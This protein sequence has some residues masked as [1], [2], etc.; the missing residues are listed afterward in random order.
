MNEK[1]NNE[2]SNLRSN[3]RNVIR[4]LNIGKIPTFINAYLVR[5]YSWK[6]HG[7]YYSMYKDDSMLFCATGLPYTPN[8]KRHSFMETLDKLIENQEMRP[9][10]LFLGGKFIKWS[11]ILIIKN[12]A[13]TYLLASHFMEDGCDYNIMQLPE[14]SVTYTE[15]NKN[16]SDEIFIFDQDGKYV[17][18]PK[19]YVPYTT[20]SI[21][22]DDVY[23]EKG[24]SKYNTKTQLKLEPEYKVQSNNI[25]LFDTEGY[26]IHNPDLFMNGLNLF[27]VKDKNRDIEPI[28]YAAFYYKKNYLCKDNIEVIANK[29]YIAKTI[30]DSNG[31][32]KYMNV[33]NKEFNFEFEPMYNYDR[34]INESLE[35]IMNY[36]PLLL[37]N[38]YKS[39][40]NI[41]IKTYTG[42]E[43]KKKVSKGYITM[44]RRID[45]ES[46]NY[47]MIFHNG[48]LYNYYHELT[49]ENKNFKFPLLGV[50][51]DDI[52]EIMYFKHIDNKVYEVRFDYDS[53]DDIV[54]LSSN[55]NIED[56]KLFTMSPQFQ[57]FNI[58]VKDTV[59]YEI[60]YHAEKQE[61]GKWKMYP[62]NAYYYNKD[63]ALVSK[64]QFRHSYS[65]INDEDCKFKLP[66]DF[67]YCNDVNRFMV[68]LNG[69]L[70]S[71]TNYKITIVKN[72]RP[73][74]DLSLYIAN[75]IQK[76]D[77]VDIFYIG[78][79]IEE[80]YTNDN[81]K[82]SGN[83]VLDASK[84]TLGFDKDL[85][86]VYVN[87]R[88]IL[89]DSISNISP[90]MLQ[91][92]EAT[93]SIHNVSIF[94]YV[95]NEQ[96]LTDLFTSTEDTL[97]RVFNS[98]PSSIIDKLFMKDTM[99]DTEEDMNLDAASMKSVLQRI[100]RDYWAKP[101]INEGGPLLYDYDVIEGMDEDAMGNI[102]ATALN[103]QDEEQL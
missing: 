26:L 39:K 74:T 28:S 79:E 25:A 46:N 52:V 67:K 44:S 37:S 89:P 8:Q 100:I 11:D 73:F 69:R 71:R 66:S 78:E 63:L 83:I 99:N 85:F 55:I 47:V 49:Y 87:G 29:D 20:I 101:F 57:E 50:Q 24:V 93:D 84:L 18:T 68:F 86:M 27:S 32:Q 13:Y 97:T 15:N 12:H 43:L 17:T 58:E 45:E 76:G 53:E 14:Y 35:Y 5:E 40:S 102:I 2:I 95:S 6:Q 41:V 30:L 64:R 61:D 96:I 75:D 81:L 54:D 48:L 82:L 42:E 98:L 103:G 91:I 1:L 19:A 92:R 31:S 33:L 51:D 21:K 70:L 65:I 77:I 59:Q 38:Y 72:T 88:K 34:N 60:P 80:I 4:Q 3:T 94:K 7:Y 9:F 23:Q 22:D 36:N 62:D 10:L 16:A 90:S 56:M